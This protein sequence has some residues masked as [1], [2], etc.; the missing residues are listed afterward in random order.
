MLKKTW[1]FHVCAGGGHYKTS[2][3]H[4]GMWEQCSVDHVGGH[5][6]QGPAFLWCPCLKCGPCPPTLSLLGQVLYNGRPQCRPPLCRPDSRILS[7]VKK[8]DGQGSLVSNS[9]QISSWVFTILSYFICLKS[10]QKKK[11]NFLVSLILILNFSPVCLFALCSG[12]FSNLFLTFGQHVF[13]SVTSLLI[14]VF[15]F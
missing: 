7:R 15:F 2:T 12:K 8:R 5:E 6:A 13:T 14:S 1:V 10:F 3:K 4:S 11:W 9:W